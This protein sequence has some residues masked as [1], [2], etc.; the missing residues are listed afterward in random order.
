[1]NV[2]Q[3][4]AAADAYEMSV[5]PTFDDPNKLVAAG[6]GV[7]AP[8]T[9]DH[10]VGIA[11]SVRMFAPGCTFTKQAK[12][13][14]SARGSR[15]TDAK[16]DT[17]GMGPFIYASNVYLDRCEITNAH[18]DI[19]L[20]LDGYFDGPKPTGIRVRWCHIHDCGPLPRK[21][22]S[23]GIYCKAVGA[24]I[25]GNYIADNADRGVQLYAPDT[26]DYPRGCIVHDN[27]ILGNGQGVVINGSHNVVCSNRIG[28]SQAGE[29]ILIGYNVG[30][31]N[32]AAG[33]YVGA[34]GIGGGVGVERITLGKGGTLDPAK[35]P[36]LD[37]WKANNG[38][39]DHA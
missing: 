29:D 2:A 38:W 30:P 32:I 17:H 36:T 39:R 1:M 5:L 6:A 26:S 33:N 20:I 12:V 27:I 37:E 24:E 13:Y 34:G 19:G 23:H 10:P 7:L 4:I 11:R 3:T 25:V 28:D 18:T 31:G 16:F 8:G 15:I 22:Y 21:N 9:Y 14:P 35:L